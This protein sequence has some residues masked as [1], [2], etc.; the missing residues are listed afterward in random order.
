MASA[1]EWAAAYARQ[2]NADFRMFQRLARESPIEACHKLLFLQM[3]CEKLVKAHL[4]RKGTDPAELQSSHA[5]IAGTLPVILRQEAVALNFAGPKARAV[6]HHAKHLAHEIELLAPAVK[7]GGQRPDNCEYP[8]Q[9][10]DGN[11]RVPLDWS[12]HPSRLIELPAG[13]T[14]LKLIQSSVNRLLASDR[15]Q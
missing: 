10:S 4:C 15:K 1:A 3:A 12:F 2:A 5:Y 14:F 8:W 13:R 9:D 11:V 7:R 6:W